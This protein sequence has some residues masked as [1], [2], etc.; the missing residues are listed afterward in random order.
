MSTKH[1]HN[2][3][4]LSKRLDL[5]SSKNFRYLWASREAYF[6]PS[7]GI[8]VLTVLSPLKNVGFDGHGP[9]GQGQRVNPMKRGRSGCHCWAT[10]MGSIMGRS[11]S[12]AQTTLKCCK[13][14]HLI[15]S[16]T[17]SSIHLK[18]I[19]VTDFPNI[20]ALL[21]LKQHAQPIIPFWS[22][23][24][25]DEEL[26]MEQQ[27]RCSSC[28]FFFS[29]LSTFTPNG[30]ISRGHQ[31]SL[32]RVLRV[33]GEAGAGRGGRNRQP[34]SPSSLSGAP[35]NVLPLPPTSPYF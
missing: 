28:S 3:L 34:P 27:H 13:S 4:N 9:L 20:S 23:A 6:E 10:I 19:T 7:L 29:F 24:C 12:T 32:G 26:D 1:A 18:N 33:Q 11:T 8:P 15:Y 30:P 17:H 21:G 31:H 25:K 22:K 16:P 5:S 35:A 2:C 14:T